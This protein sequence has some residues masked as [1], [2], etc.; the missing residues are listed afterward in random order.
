LKS[1]YLGSSLLPARQAISLGKAG[2]PGMSDQGHIHIQTMKMAEGSSYVCMGKGF[3]SAL[4]ETLGV[5]D[6]G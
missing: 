2:S 5:E 4:A 6:Y 1:N 3:L